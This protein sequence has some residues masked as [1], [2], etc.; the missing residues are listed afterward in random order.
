MEQGTLYNIHIVKLNKG[1]NGTIVNGT[2]HSIQNGTIVNGTGHSIQMQSHL[3]LRL[4][5]CGLLCL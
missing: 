1:Q 2:G 5:L 4:S 3:K